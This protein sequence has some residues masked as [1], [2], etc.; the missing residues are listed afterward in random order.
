MVVTGAVGML[1]VTSTTFGSGVELRDSAPFG[2]PGRAR[3][4][5]LWHLLL[6]G[7]V[8]VPVPIT[9]F[10]SALPAAQVWSVLA[11]CAGFA[12]W[13]WA[14]LVRAPHRA[15]G[16]VPIL[17]YWVGAAAFV[18]VATGYDP[19]FVVVLYGFYPLAFV[20]LGWWGMA[21]IVVLP[22]L[23]TW[24]SGGSGWVSLFATAA[25]AVVIL[26][27]L[28]AIARQSEERRAALEELEATR[29][30]LAAAARHTG[31]LEER[32]RLAREMHDTV[33]QGLASIVMHLEAADQALEVEPCTARSHLDIARRSARD[34]LDEVRRSVHALRPDLLVGASLAQAL[35]GTAKRWS[36]DHATPAE[37]RVTGEPVELAPDSETALLRVAQ[38]SL[39]NVARHARATRAVVTLSYLGDIVTL[40]VDDDG[41]G[42]ST[43]SS[44]HED[45]GFGI[46]GMRER[47]TAVGGRLD[48]ESSPGDGTTV[49]ASVPV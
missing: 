19:S 38:E 33:A 42:F 27:V 46:V 3:P 11:L 34:G 29:A 44:P 40:D 18:G 17:V 23:A 10:G 5:P 22:A 43:A 39:T 9:V 20:T 8:L 2:P 14:F 1:D 36:A 25:L 28:Q 24:R 37:V 21:P 26:L 32:Q 48:V 4:G 47:I 30:E 13:H 6:A 12:V 7:V 16:V 35:H 49:A 15:P 41:A 45:G 31:V